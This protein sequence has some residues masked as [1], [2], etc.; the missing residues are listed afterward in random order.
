MEQLLLLAR[1]EEETSYKLSRA[2]LV[3]L[4]REITDDFTVTAP[5][6]RWTFIATQ[7]EV[8]I[9]CDSSALRRVITN[10]L[11]NARKHTSVGNS[12]TVS[13]LADADVGQ[14]VLRVQDTGEGIDPSSCRMSLNASPGPTLPVRV[15]TAPPA[16]AC[17]SP[18]ASCRRTA[19]PSRSLPSP[20]T[21]FLR[22]GCRW[23]IRKRRLRQK[24]RRRRGQKA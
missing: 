5:D 7:D 17:P 15:P 8:A 13:V 19:A 4:A 24:P 16:W 20:G 12:V 11:G 22:C 21:P 18:R 9:N 2:N 10:L 23:P 6:H 3:D 14:A 1:L